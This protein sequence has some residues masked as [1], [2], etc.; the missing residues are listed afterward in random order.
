MWF[1]KI[2]DSGQNPRKRKIL[3]LS[4]TSSSKPYGIK[5]CV[6]LEATSF[7]LDIDYHQAKNTQLQN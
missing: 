1:T 2:L 7:G 5:L 3:S 4:D 6:H